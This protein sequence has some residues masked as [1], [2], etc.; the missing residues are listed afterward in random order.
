MLVFNPVHIC[1]TTG[2][3]RL[4][5]RTYCG[6]NKRVQHHRTRILPFSEKVTMASGSW[7]LEQDI[8]EAILLFSGRN[9]TPYTGL[10]FDVL[11]FR[12]SVLFC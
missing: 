7:V 1:L 12:S 8:T 5:L 2:F 10:W 11:L 9:G 6:T 3:P 4:G